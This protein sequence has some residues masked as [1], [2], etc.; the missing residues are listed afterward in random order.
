[1]TLPRLVSVEKALACV[2]LSVVVVTSAWWWQ[3]QTTLRRLQAERV[4]AT[5]VGATYARAEVPASVEVGQPWR[6][7]GPQSTGGDWIYELFTPPV[8][9]YHTLAKVFTVTPPMYLAE[10]KNLPFGLELVGVKFEPFRLQLVG[11]LGSSGDYIGT[12][13][14]DRAPQTFIGRAGARFAPLGLELK[15][16]E[17][18]R[19]NVAS[20]DAS[21]VYDFAGYAV[22]RDEASGTEVTLDTRAPKLT[23]TP[24]AVLRSLD[25]KPGKPRV[26]HEGDSFQQGDATYRIERIQMDP[27]EVVV[28][29][30]TT[31]L[32]YPE[33][34][35]LKPEVASQS[36]ASESKLARQAA[37]HAAS[38]L[39][40]A[41][42]Q[43]R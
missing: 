33:T 9:Y 37:P 3:Q 12:F 6:K 25:D 1:M 7:P 11:Y 28:A 38:N 23:D 10:K 22:L 8:I 2:A 4:T 41:G 30:Q 36:A 27:P 20:Q 15:S 24:L 35:V 16:F 40:N 5:L 34:R 19:V 42:N 29:K 26:L 32:P 13:V 21:P 14:S 43:T 17:I 18:R 31:G 39:A